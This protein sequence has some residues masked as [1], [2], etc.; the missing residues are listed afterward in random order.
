[1]SLAFLPSSLVT[2]T[3]GLLERGDKGEEEEARSFNWEKRNLLFEEEGGG[4][5]GG[6]GGDWREKRAMETCWGSRVF[7]FLALLSP[8]QHLPTFCFPLEMAPN[9]PSIIIRL[10]LSLTAHPKRAWIWFSFNPIGYNM[11]KF[12]KNKWGYLHFVNL[13]FALFFTFRYRK[14]IIWHFDTPNSTHFLTFMP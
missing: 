9:T 1:M 7:F 14:I 12:P 2:T 6:G 10:T 11:A 5:R 3:W 8:M 13:K 4:Q